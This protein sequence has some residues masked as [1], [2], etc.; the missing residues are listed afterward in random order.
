MNDF[1]AGLLFAV[2]PAVGAGLAFGLMHVGLGITVGLG[3]FLLGLD[4]CFHKNN[5]EQR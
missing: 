4:I 5:K 2:I 1:F 3:V